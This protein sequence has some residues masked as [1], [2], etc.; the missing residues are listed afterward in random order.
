[1]APR[2]DNDYLNGMQLAA[3]G[4]TPAMIRDFLGS[5]DHTEYIPRFRNA[6][7]MLQ[8]ALGRV[9]A[10]ERTAKFVERLKLAARRSTAAREAWDRRREEMLRLVADEVP[11]PRL[12]ADVLTDRAVR[13]S[14]PRD[15]LH[16]QRAD[17]NTLNRWKVNYL[18]Q[19]LTRFDATIE[20]MFGQ[21]G[22]AAAEKSLRRRALV[23]IGETY[24]D[25]LWECQR[26]LRVNE[27]RR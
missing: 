10:A 5:P 21:I 16:A 6:A 24:P 8:F 13:H 26:Q 25:L 14:D 18:R 9:V 22:R 4:W 23:T 15:A 7:P 27:R 2:T 11:I 3:R 19:E 1:M 20:G 17:R 12:S